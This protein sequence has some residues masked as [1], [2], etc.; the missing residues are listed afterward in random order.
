MVYYHHTT[1]AIFSIFFAFR[2][3]FDDN[4][5]K[6]FKD[7]KPGIK[8]AWGAITRRR[9]SSNASS[10]STSS[11]TSNAPS[12]VGGS[13]GGSSSEGDI[14]SINE[15]DEEGL[16]VETPPSSAAGDGEGS[17]SMMSNKGKGPE[18]VTLTKEGLLVNQPPGS[19][20]NNDETPFEGGQPLRRKDSDAYSDISSNALSDTETDLDSR[21]ALITARGLSESPS[22]TPGMGPSGHFYNHARN[23]HHGHG[24]ENHEG[25]RSGE[26]TPKR[27]HSPPRSPVDDKTTHPQHWTPQLSEYNQHPYTNA[28]STAGNGGG[29]GSTPGSGANTPRRRMSMGDMST[30]FPGGINSSDGHSHSNRKGMSVFGFDEAQLKN[31]LGQ[32]DLNSRRR[33][34]SYHNHDGDQQQQNEEEG[35]TE[36][37]EVIT[38]E[39]VNAQEEVPL[40]VDSKQVKGAGMEVAV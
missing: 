30:S 3:V 16:E 26:V 8:K 39:S 28:T 22:Y 21:E 7:L 15:E 5:V 32:M 17:T 10:A 19:E 9:S 33:K 37:A 24:D 1:P 20:M 34:P 29:S 12:Q 4:S 40:P 25:V 23:H 35:S 2:L 6:T 14:S 13:G 27:G 36:D 11:T 38:K 31:R 18:S